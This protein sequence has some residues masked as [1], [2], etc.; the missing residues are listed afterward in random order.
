MTDYEKAL[1]V[2][3]YLTDKLREAIK[4]YKAKIYNPRDLDFSERLNRSTGEFEAYYR[5]KVTLEFDLQKLF[6]SNPQLFEQDFHTPLND[7]EALKDSQ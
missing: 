2:M 4:P 1:I 3:V 5:A 6:L 7:Q